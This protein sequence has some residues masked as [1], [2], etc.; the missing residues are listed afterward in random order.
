MDF[1]QY[2]KVMLQHPMP[3]NYATLFF[4]VPFLSF[5]DSG[6]MI[7]L[8]P[9]FRFSGWDSCHESNLRRPVP[10]QPT[11]QS[12]SNDKNNNVFEMAFYLVFDFDKICQNYISDF[13]RQL[14]C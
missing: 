5:F 2:L 6:F 13:P 1:K 14:S 3:L 7:S 10:L 4:F 11:L 12:T 9:L 8:W